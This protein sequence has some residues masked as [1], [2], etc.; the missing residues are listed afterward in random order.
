MPLVPR[1]LGADKCANEFV[2]EFLANHAATQNQNVHVIVLH[3]LM[4][5]VRVVTQSGANPRKFVRG[6]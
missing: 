4:G 1:G 6:Y 3:P 2:R 5:R